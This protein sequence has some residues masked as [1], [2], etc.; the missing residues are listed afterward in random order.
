MATINERLAALE[1][2]L[3]GVRSVVYTTQTVITDEGAVEELVGMDVLQNTRLETVETGQVTLSASITALET[4]ITGL[5][6]LIDALEATAD[7]HE[8]RL[9]ALE[10]TSYG[11]SVYPGVALA[12]GMAYGVTWSGAPPAT[13]VYPGVATG[14]GAAGAV[15]WTGGYETPRA[16]ALGALPFKLGT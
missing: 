3:T 13:F 1:A 10:G 5:Q 15:S 16:D 2:A 11:A 8:T 14:T 12:S 7:D 6:S 4:S 9:L